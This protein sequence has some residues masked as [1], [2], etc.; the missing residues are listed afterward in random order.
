MV[1]EYV[2]TTVNEHDG[3][4]VGPK[5]DLLD[6]CVEE[7]KEGLL[8]GLTDGAFDGSIDGIVV[9]SVVDA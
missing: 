8:D 7:D 6:G 2:E 3:L 1:G 5:D 9:G 4:I